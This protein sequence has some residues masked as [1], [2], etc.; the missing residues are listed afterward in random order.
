[1]GLFGRLFKKKE[2]PLVKRKDE[3]VADS[4]R[5][6]MEEME[7]IQEL[8]E[9]NMD[10]DEYH[11]AFNQACRLIPKRRYAEAILQ[12]TSIRETTADSYEK[13]SC[14]NL[15]GACHFFLGDFEKALECY[16]ESFHSGYDKE[17]MDYNVWEVCEE[18]MKRDGNK[19]TWSRYYLE[20]F[21]DGQ[22]AGKAKKRL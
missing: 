15:I 6:S 7:Q 20:L 19:E 14:E 13:A 16:T 22:Y 3:L 9:D 12:F 10:A 1:M 8:L 17:V 21:P 11:S 18:L 2:K 4:S 5:L